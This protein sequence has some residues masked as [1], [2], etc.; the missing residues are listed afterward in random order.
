MSSEVGGGGGSEAPRSIVALGGRRRACGGTATRDRPLQGGEDVLGRLAGLARARAALEGADGG[1]RHRA[2]R[3]IGLVA[4]ELEVDQRLLDGADLV[5]DGLGPARRV[6]LG[7]GGRRWPDAGTGNAAG[8]S[9][10]AGRGAG[11][12]SDG[13]RGGG[14]L[15]GCRASTICLNS[16]W[17]ACCARSRSPGSRVDRRACARCAAVLA[18]ALSPP[19]RLVWRSNSAVMAYQA[20]ASRRILGHEVAAFVDVAQGEHRGGQALAT[21][22]AQQIDRLLAVAR[23]AFAF[24]QHQG[25]MLLGDRQVGVGGL[26]VPF[27]GARRIALDDETAFVHHADIEGRLRRAM[28]GGAQQPAGAG[29]L[30]L[31]HA[32]ALHQAARHLLH[33]GKLVGAGSGPELVDRQRGPVDRSGWRGG[34]RFGRAGCRRLG[35]VSGW[36]SR[37][38]R[39][40]RWSA[41]AERR[42][43]EPRSAPRTLLPVSRARRAGAASSGLRRRCAARMPGGARSATRRPFPA[44]PPGS[45]RRPGERVASRPCPDFSRQRPRRRSQ[46]AMAHDDQAW[47]ATG[48]RR[49]DGRS[50]ARY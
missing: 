21:G 19:P 33:G 14:G 7:V 32:D 11:G 40:R 50:P 43:P 10:G 37:R 30:V 46:R 9:A 39:T 38:A 5:V 22:R 3:A 31:G 42:P 49:P 45:R 13:T 48:P 8:G 35:A 4:Q 41:R 26:A 23:D 15:G 28:L 20:S 16:T 34:G 25:E 17:P 36:P 24:A 47:S 1:A 44:L 6:G 27:D 29:L 18:M 12:R 2:D